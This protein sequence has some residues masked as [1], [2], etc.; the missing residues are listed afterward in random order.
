MEVGLSLDEGVS[1]FIGR[2]Y[3]AVHDAD[4]WR[5]V[6][7]DLLERTGSRLA[8]ICHA[9]VRHKEFSRSE[10]YGPETSAFDV[11][12][13]EYSEAMY[14][15]DPS[16]AWASVNP[17]AGVCDTSLIMAHEEFRELEY[18]KWQESRFGTRHWR[19]FYTQPVDDLS[20][21]LSLHPPKDA[22]PASPKT[23]RLHLLL[24]EHM[25]RS[26]RLAARPPDLSANDEAV[27]ILDTAGKVLS[28]SDR[29]EQLLATKDGLANDSG[30]LHCASLDATANLSCAIASAVKSGV[31]GGAGGG[32]RV[33]RKSGKPDWLAL[34]IPC[35]Q[36]L[37][38]LPVRTAAAVLRIV[39]TDPVPSLL[40]SH[41]ELFDLSPR[42]AG[43][44]SALL[45]GH[46]I[47]SLCA[48]LDISRNT[49]KVHLQSIFRKTGTNRQSEL[50]HLLSNVTRS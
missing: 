36:H 42:E 43:V 12:A 29:A 7:G 17:N 39:D 45:A 11:G 37:E 46:S 14:T 38:H 16:L 31:L 50:V 27:I 2:L 22:G 19:V 32:V 47:E 28:M 20:F 40:P 6:I 26:L 4:A 13:D 49:A 41:A 25:E 30:R 9:D 1:R 15:S 24:F 33:A 48:S 8:F 23:A 10:F 34:V 35:P 5:S 44:A 21:A 3:E 18:V